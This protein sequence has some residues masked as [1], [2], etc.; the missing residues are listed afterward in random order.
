MKEIMKNPNVAL[1]HNLFIAHGIGENIGNPLEE[2][3]RELKEELKKIFCT[4]YHKHVYEED[5]NTCIL[6]ITLTDSLVFAHDYKYFV[7]FKQKT[8]TREECVI[9]IVF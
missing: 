7:D 9:D 4:F 3:N 5:T 8:A 1:N 2:Q 6:K